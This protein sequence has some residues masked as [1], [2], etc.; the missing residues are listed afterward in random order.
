MPL[1]LGV[2]ADNTLWD[3][4]A[5]FKAAQLALLQSL[6][7]ADLL[8]DPVQELEHLRHLDQEISHYLQ[9]NEYNFRTLAVALTLYYSQHLSDRDSILEALNHE[10][11]PALLP[12]VNAAHDRFLQSL[13]QTP[14]LLP[15]AA[16]LVQQL[17]TWSMERPDVVVL[18]ISEGQIDRIETILAYHHFLSAFPH[19]I[20]GQV[21]TPDLFRSIRAQ[22]QTR[23]TDSC[24]M[25]GD[26]YHR[27]IWPSQQAGF[28]TVYIP[29]GFH[30]SEPHEH[31][32]TLTLPSLEAF[33]PVLRDIVN[34]RH[35][36]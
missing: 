21:K 26:S 8:D 27:D 29:G 15:G 6:A 33:L 5:R 25:V 9:R 13:N 32:P 23:P 17:Q 10:P 14:T 2:D 35:L 31:S 20:L 1:L 28:H 7:T 36:D 3:T 16:T 24:W 12:L 22:Y 30:G 4:N 34:C 18:L 11:P 19:R